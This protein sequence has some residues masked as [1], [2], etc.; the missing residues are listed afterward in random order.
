MGKD[1]RGLEPGAGISPGSDGFYIG[2]FTAKYGQRNQKLFHRLQEC[3]QWLG[4]SLY[5]DES[6]IQCRMADEGYRSVSLTD[7]AIDILHKQ[8][9]LYVHTTEDEKHKEIKEIAASLKVV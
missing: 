4:D 3:R 9:N 5:Q 6:S 2:R 7:E 8:K 1:L